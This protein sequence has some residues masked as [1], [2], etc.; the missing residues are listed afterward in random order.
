MTR[1]LTDAIIMLL[2]GVG[3]VLLSPLGH[4]VSEAWA[5]GAL[6]AGFIVIV[7]SFLM[8]RGRA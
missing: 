8:M 4:M 5:W 3:M 2:V 1:P 7:G 6:L